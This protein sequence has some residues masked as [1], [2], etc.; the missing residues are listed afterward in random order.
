MG[1]A[2]HRYSKQGKYTR[3]GKK[4]EK[5]E[6]TIRGVEHKKAVGSGWKEGTE[7]K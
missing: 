7:V 6:E 2:L 1:G 5:K 4:S 3:G